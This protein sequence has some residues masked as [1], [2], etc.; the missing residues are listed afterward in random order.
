[1]EIDS[2]NIHTSSGPIAE[3]EAPV[4]HPDKDPDQFSFTGSNFETR[5]VDE[6]KEEK[7]VEAASSE[8]KEPA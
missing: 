2:K 7:G 6:E 3:L 5:R 1:M 8:K 4:H